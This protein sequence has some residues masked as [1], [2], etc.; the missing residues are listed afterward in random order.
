MKLNKFT[1]LLLML[2]LAWGPAI[3]AVVLSDSV[4]TDRVMT[5]ITMPGAAMLDMQQCGDSCEMSE[6]PCGEGCM[7]DPGCCVQVSAAIYL[8][9]ELVVYSDRQGPG[10]NRSAA[11]YSFL[12]YH[13]IYHPPRQSAVS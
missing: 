1:A 12:Q 8:P 5:S 11:S 2:L 3:S 9:A 13:L 7:P 6:A 4:P 10:N